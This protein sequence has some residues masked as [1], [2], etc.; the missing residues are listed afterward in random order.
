[1]IEIKKEKE[2]LIAKATSK[3]HKTGE[4]LFNYLSEIDMHKYDV[5][6]RQGVREQTR[7]E[8]IED[9]KSFYSYWK[10]FRYKGLSLEGSSNMLQHL[11]RLFPE[12]KELE[13]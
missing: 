11:E 12:L 10:Q 13:K 4:H 6:V 7:K 5:L 3:G 1:M 8:V 9:I 2:K